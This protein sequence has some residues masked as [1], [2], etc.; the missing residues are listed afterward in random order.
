MRWILALFACGVLLG[1]EVKLGKPLTLTQAT[2]IP[3]ISA[4]PA[5]YS[6]KTVLVRGKVTE[7][8]EMMGCWMKLVDGEQSLRVKVNDGEIVFPKTAIGKTALAEGKLMEIKL[9]REQAIARA[10]H[11]AEEQKRPFRAESIK[12]GLTIYQIQGTGAV[13]SE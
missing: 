8:C 10:R 2:P 9:T 5:Q 4:H 7:V 11:E 1:A 3:E 6:G 13:V 12:S